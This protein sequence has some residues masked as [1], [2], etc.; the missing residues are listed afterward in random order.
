M[1]VSGTGRGKRWSVLDVVLNRR[2]AASSGNY[3]LTFQDCI[4][5][6]SSGV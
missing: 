1:D 4:S 5:V 6:Q 3:I 2:V